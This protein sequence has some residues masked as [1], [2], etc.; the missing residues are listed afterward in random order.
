MKVKEGVILHMDGT[1]K[2]SAGGFQYRSICKDLGEGQESK[3]DTTQQVL[4]GR[5]RVAIQKSRECQTAH[6]HLDI[7]L[8]RTISEGSDLNCLPALAVQL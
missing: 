7:S 2:G 3:Q 5:I 1:V 6:T 4:L 8:D